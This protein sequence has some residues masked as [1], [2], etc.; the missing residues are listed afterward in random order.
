MLNSIKNELSKSFSQIKMF[1]FIIVLA[2]APL[3]GAIGFKL[4]KSQITDP[5]ELEMLSFSGMSFPLQMLGGLVD[6][7]IP[8]FIIILV[9]DKITE[10]YKQ[11]TLILPLITPISRTKL[12]LSKILTIGIEITVLFCVL[13]GSSYLFG[14]IFFGYESGFSHGLLSLSTV[15]GVLYTLGSFALTGLILF[16][17]SLIVIMLSL[18]FKSSGS[19]I[20]ISVGMIFVMQMMSLLGKNFSKLLI[21]NYFKFYMTIF[22]PMETLDYLIGIL[23]IMLYGIVGIVLSFTIFKKKDLIY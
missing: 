8:I 17:F 19:L 15:N 1:I 16:I 3:V 2:G 21:S 18:I 23:I 11:G 12:L 22:Y 14:I 4:L 13:F 20:G 9:A 5:K 7:L 6:F 10:E